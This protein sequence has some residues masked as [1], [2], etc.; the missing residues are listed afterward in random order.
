[1]KR[2]LELIKLGPVFSYFG[3]V[4]TKDTTGKYPTNTNLK[5]M[6]GINKISIVMFL[7]AVC[8]LIFRALNRE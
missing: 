3:R 7:I 8:V 2:F 5:M 4:F 1:M 6:H